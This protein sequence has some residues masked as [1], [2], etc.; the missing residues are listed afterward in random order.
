[1]GVVSVYEAVCDSCAMA[2]YVHGVNNKKE[3]KT[4]LE[5]RGYILIGNCQQIFCDET[6]ERNGAS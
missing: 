2:D 1:M 6:C 4:E 5:A 3:L